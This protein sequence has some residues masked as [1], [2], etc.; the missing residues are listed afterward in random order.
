MHD[1]LDLLVIGSGYAGLWAALSAARQ[2]AVLGA[3]LRIAM[4]S[5][6]PFLTARPR[7]YEFGL[8][9]VDARIAIGDALREVDVEF[10]QGE[11]VGLER[12]AVV[13]A[14]GR[15]LRARALLLATG[16]TVAT[17]VMP[18]AMQYCANADSA[19]AAQSMWQ[20]A[21]ALPDHATIVVLGGG[22]TGIE[23]ACELAGW[24]RTA[25]PALQVLLLDRGAI[26][27]GYERAS[28]RAI[29]DV[30]AQLGVTMLEGCTVE[31][32]DAGRLQL[33]DGTAISCDL[34]VWAGGLQT[35]ALVP[36]LAQLSATTLYADGRLEVGRTLQLANAANWF[37]AGD[38]AA[39]R[40]E[41]GHRTTFSCQHALSLGTCAGHNAV[42]WLC[43]A[44]LRDYAPRPY[45]TCLDLG[46]DTA[47]LTRGFTRE[48][49][50]VGPA[51]KPTKQ[52]INRRLIVPP[53]AGGRAALLAGADPDEA[54]RV[55]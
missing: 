31:R 39:A 3:T 41:D 43:A 36:A 51:V 24:R 52:Y 12:N 42:S 25:K 22:F 5:R 47:L 23:L 35:S 21:S 14:D 1:D 33:E 46:P 15:M 4:V 11:V 9:S 54:A 20:R 44:A 30:L 37:A 10:I 32:V 6:E 28:R 53:T 16:S 19:A 34:P 2:R 13:L 26:A 50:N 29:T 55:D 8:Q 45:A 48:L 49:V 7:L 18:G 38:V 17:P 27:A 40:V